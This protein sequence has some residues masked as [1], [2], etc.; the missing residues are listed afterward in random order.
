MDALWVLPPLH[1]HLINVVGRAAREEAVVGR[2]GVRRGRGVALLGGE[3]ERASSGGER[4]TS[5]GDGRA[6]RWLAASSKELAARSSKRTQHGS[7]LMLRCRGR[8][9]RF[10]IG[11]VCCSQ[12]Y[13]RRVTSDF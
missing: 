5:L 11:V 12:W 8:F 9:L 2:R 6:S 3:G 4:E 7:R 1:I 13:V 10:D